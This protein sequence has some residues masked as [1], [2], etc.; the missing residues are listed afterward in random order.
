PEACWR[1]RERTLASALPTLTAV[2]TRGKRVIQYSRASVINCGAAAYW[3]PA[4]AGYDS[5][6]WHSTAQRHLPSQLRLVA[7]HD[8]GLAFRLANFVWSWITS[9]ML[10][11]TARS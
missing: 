6:P 2:I 8:F 11:R 5:Q 9:L 4:F 1:A 7:R 10:G 3:I